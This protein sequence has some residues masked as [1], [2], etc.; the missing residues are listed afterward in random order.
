MEH[1]ISCL[2]KQKKSSKFLSLEIY[3]SLGLIKAPILQI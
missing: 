1:R 3:V 2:E